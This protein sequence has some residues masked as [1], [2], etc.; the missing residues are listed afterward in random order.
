[1]N[2]KCWVKTGGNALTKV[3]I[4]IEPVRQ[5]PTYK[6]AARDS[7]HGVIAQAGNTSNVALRHT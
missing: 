2:E 4:A 6:I 7:P 1:M 5:H 3:V